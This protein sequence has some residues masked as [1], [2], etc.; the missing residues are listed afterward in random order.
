MTEDV[1]GMLCDLAVVNVLEHVY[2]LY[3]WSNN[4]IIRM[5]TIS[6]HSRWLNRV[7]GHF[8]DGS[9]VGC[10][11]FVLIGSNI[12]CYNIFDIDTF[13]SGLIVYLC[14]ARC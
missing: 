9:F 13:Y 5:L 14:V 3:Y 8:V 4:G 12:F 2:W 7:I 6:N 11:D 10:L 1:F